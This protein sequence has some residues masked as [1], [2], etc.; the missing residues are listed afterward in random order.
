MSNLKICAFADEAD[1]SVDGQIKALNDNGVEYIEVRGVDGKNISD[2]TA[3]EAKELYS[4]YTNGGIKVW[5]IGSPI[6]KINIDDDFDKEMERFKRTVETG[7][8]MQAKCIRLFSFYGTGGKKEYADKVFERLSKYVDAAKGSGITLCHENEKGIYGE[9][10]PQCLEI[11]KAI[12]EIKCVFDPANFIQ[13]SQDIPEAWE[14]LKNYVCYHHIKDATA[15]GDVVPPGYGIAGMKKYLAEYSAMG[16][17]VLTVE[18]HLTAFVGL[19]KLAKEDERNHM[20][21]FS[22]GSSSE[23][24]AFA[25]SSLRDVIK[26][27]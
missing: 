7:V 22:F 27:I 6:G 2:I 14:M 23:A 25:I 5:S 11:L 1:S 17:G 19:D 10:A 21:R 16:G 20:G 8:I 4:R 9:L 24:F 13:A 3:A 12:P 15:N 26:D 18:P